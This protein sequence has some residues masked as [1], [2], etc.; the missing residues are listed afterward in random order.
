MTSPRSNA[1]A[2]IQVAIRSVG[3]KIELRVLFLGNDTRNFS[4]DIHSKN[5]LNFDNRRV[6]FVLSQQ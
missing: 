4:A 1:T 6:H 2:A 5:A 3:I